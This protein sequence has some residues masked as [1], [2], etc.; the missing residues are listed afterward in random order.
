MLL[1]IEFDCMKIKYKR[2]GILWLVGVLLIGVIVLAHKQKSARLSVTQN[3]PTPTSSQ[4]YPVDAV[5]DSVY[6]N[7]K[8]GFK[9]EYPK[10]IFKVKPSNTMP[11]NNGTLKREWLSDYSNNLILNVEIMQEKISKI[12]YPEYK[13]LL[14]L[15]PGQSIGSPD[16]SYS[17]KINAPENT[18]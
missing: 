13:T 11:D 14:T 8:Y 16:A 18:N 12:Y 1:G 17:Q 6:T 15:K 4:Q 10:E 5:N 2:K 7:Y 9:F 3:S